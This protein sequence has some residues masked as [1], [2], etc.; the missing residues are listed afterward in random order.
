MRETVRINEYYVGI[1]NGLSA[2]V[3]KEKLIPNYYEICIIG[4]KDS[5]KDCLKNK[6]LY[7][8]CEKNIDIY[9]FCISRTINITG[10]EIK[11]DVIVKRDEN[12][13]DINSEFYYIK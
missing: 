5:G 1:E 10:K 7:D 4:D 8:C 11:F 6:F 3:E 2:N 12:N 13:K 9:E